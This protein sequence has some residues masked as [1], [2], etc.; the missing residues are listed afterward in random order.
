MVFN[1]SVNVPFGSPIGSQNA[2]WRQTQIL[3]K[4][5]IRRL[6]DGDFLK[7]TRPN[8]GLPRAAIPLPEGEPNGNFL[9]SF[10]PAIFL[11][12]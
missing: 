12:G 10:Y 9:K 3:P 4:N 8:L 11:S 2:A 1:P 5:T 7:Q 6:A